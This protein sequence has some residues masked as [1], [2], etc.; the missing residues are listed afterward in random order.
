[1][2]YSIV[3]INIFKNEMEGNHDFTIKEI[4][5][6]GRIVKIFIFLEKLVKIINIIIYPTQSSTIS[7]NN[8]HTLMTLKYYTF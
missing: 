5:K 3:N 6:F 8:V 2:I 4:S 7:C 1:M